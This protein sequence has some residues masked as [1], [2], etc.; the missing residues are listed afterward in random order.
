MMCLTPISAGGRGSRKC[1]LHRHLPSANSN[2]QLALAIYLPILL[3]TTTAIAVTIF[4]YRN[5]KKRKENERRH[6]YFEGLE[7]QASKE[8]K[9]HESAGL[10]IPDEWEISEDRLLLG[11]VLGEGAFGIVRKGLLQGHSQL[12]PLME[13]AVKMLRDDPTTDDIRQFQQEINMVKSVGQHPNIVSIIGCCTHRQSLRL[14]V[15]YCAL[16]DLQNYLRKV[17]AYQSVPLNMNK[18]N[19]S[20]EANN[21]QI[22]YAELLQTPNSE[23]GDDD[24]DDREI[25]I[26][27]NKLYFEGVKEEKVPQKESLSSTDLL[28]FAR[29]IA[30]GMEFLA[31]NRIVHRDLA[32]RNVLVCS[33]KMVKISDFGLSRDIYERN[34]YHKKG[35]GKLPIKWMAI[36]SLLYQVYTTQSDI[37]SFGIL[38]W[39]IVTLGGNPY[40][41]IRADR[42]YKLLQSGYRMECPQGC[43]LELY[44]IMLS[45]WKA[46]PRDRPTFSELCN[47]LDELLESSTPQ[48]YLNLNLMILDSPSISPEENL[49]SEDQR[50]ISTSKTTKNSWETEPFKLSIAEQSPHSISLYVNM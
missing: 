14:I 50:N 33:N 49:H 9:A 7:K 17:S 40:P 20:E 48:Q 38:L 26:V 15:E 31:S 11:D 4:L 36:E 47:K 34:V 30:M 18:L 21:G 37:W 46:K 41:S 44:Q 39:E 35:A 45:C 43:S 12:E 10:F 5:Y 3:I 22:K 1:S 42:V 27:V 13:V 23:N 32:A 25:G 8:I 29:Q 16:G 24:D 28:S 6:Q 19:V 2:G